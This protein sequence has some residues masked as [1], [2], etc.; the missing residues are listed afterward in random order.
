MLFQH[1]PNHIAGYSDDG[2]FNG[3]RTSV[4]EVAKY[5][6]VDIEFTPN[7]ATPK[8]DI[9]DLSKSKNVILDAVL[10]TYNPLEDF[11]RLKQNPA[12]F[13]KLRVEYPFRR[14]FG[15]YRVTGAEEHYLPILKSLGF[16]E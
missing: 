9:I 6:G 4:E 8:N 16:N 11:E 10:A 3:S 7:R 13:E 2:K 5:L 15:A 1:L 14:E 12:N